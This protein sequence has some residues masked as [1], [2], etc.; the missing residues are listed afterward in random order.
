M[1]AAT[2]AIA[3][4]T[5]EGGALRCRVI[6][7]GA[8]RGI[9]GSGLVDAVAAGLDL[10]RIE[11]GGRLAG[12]ARSFPLETAVALSQGDVRELQLAKGAIAAGF[13]ILLGRAGAKASDVPRLYLAGAFGN[14]INRASAR[15]IGLLEFPLDVIRSAGN[16]ALR[17]AKVAL[18]E[19]GGPGGAYDDLR[20]RIEHVPLAADPQFQDLYAGSMAFP[21]AS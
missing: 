11:P 17:G 21:A 16:T 7:G 9:C 6:G 1:R 3:E 20:R 18:F 8:P 4:V 19:T 13:R 5:A 2:G 12:G 14:Y 10:G 15:R